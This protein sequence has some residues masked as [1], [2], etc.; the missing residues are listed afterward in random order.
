MCLDMRNRFHDGHLK[1]LLVLG[2]WII[3]TNCC[4]FCQLAV[5]RM[6]LGCTVA[7]D[8]LKS[9]LEAV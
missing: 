3:L 2:S 5:H 6:V 9:S 4:E 7:K 1:L 8:Q